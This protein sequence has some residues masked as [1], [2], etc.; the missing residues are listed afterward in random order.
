LRK[1]RTQRRVG[2][3]VSRKRIVGIEECRKGWGKRYARAR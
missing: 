3:A 1:K 2:F